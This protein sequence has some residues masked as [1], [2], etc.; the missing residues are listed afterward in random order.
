MLNPN[1]CVPSMGSNSRVQ[2]PNTPLQ[3]EVLAKCKGVHREVE[4]EA[5]ARQTLDLTSR[6][7]IRLNNIG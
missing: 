2:V 4:S 7:Y 6:N 1:V 5:S 3:Q